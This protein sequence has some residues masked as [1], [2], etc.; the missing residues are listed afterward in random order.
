MKIGIHL[1]IDTD[2]LA[3]LE[4]MAD[5]AGCDGVQEYLRQRIKQMIREDEK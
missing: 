2:D 3:K 1:R 5:F 4:T